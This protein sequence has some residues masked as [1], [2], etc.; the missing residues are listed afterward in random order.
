[1]REKLE[2]FTQQIKLLWSNSSK[3]QKI[4]FI[5]ISSI[6]VVLIAVITVITSS[7]NYV[8]LYTNLSVQEVGQIKEELD[9]KNIPYEL[10]GGGTTI[11]VPEEQSEQLLVEL[12]GQGIPHSGNI[13]YSFFS[14]NTSWGITDNEFNI[15]KLDAMQTELANLI[16]GIEGIED[17]QVMI[18]LP[19]QSVFVSDSVEEASASIVLHTQFGYEFKGN[20][21]ES[22]YHLVSKAVPNLPAENIVIMNQNFEYFE[23]ANGNGVVEEYSDKQGIK[24]DIERDIQKRLQQMLG[25]MVGMDRVVVSVTSDVDFTNEKRIEELVEPVDIDNME[26]IPVSVESITETFEGNQAA[27][28]VPGTGDE[29][30]ANYPGLVEGQDG[31]YELVKD[32]INYE[33]N[34]IH[35]DIAE[36]PYKIRDLGIQV[37]VDSVRGIENDELQYL[38]QQEQ[39]TVEQGITSILNSMIMTSIDKEYG[40]INPEEKVSIVFQEFNGKDI[41]QTGNAIPMIPAWVYVAGGILLVVIIL[42]IVLLIRNRRTEETEEVADELA[43]SLEDVEVEDIGSQPRT[44]S[45]VQKEQLEKMAKEKPEDFAKLLRSWIS[46]D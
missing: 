38:T 27:G 9:A 7:T 18:N 16:K 25:V 29:D 45:D 30:I 5:S 42:L 28:G 3:K 26:G 35:K 11:K 46:E 17:A 21:I 44:E 12:A 22:L 2:R 31:D 32:T 13:D 14:E 39:N 34:R 10:E 41:N 15:M 33:L 43:A 19:Q 36:T 8:P 4:A 40:E 37:V 20:Q 6:L 23:Q 1:M 24:R